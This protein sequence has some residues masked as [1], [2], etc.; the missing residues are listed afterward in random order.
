M[1]AGENGWS[2]TFRYQADGVPVLFPQGS[3]A[4]TVTITGQAITAFAYLC[5][6]YNQVDMDADSAPDA[7]GQQ[8]PLLPPSMA[9][10][11]ASLRPG[12]ELSIGY[13]DNG[14]DPLFA[15]WLDY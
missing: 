13:V 2:V 5:R 11:I 3:Q 8:S 6:S 1:E 15:R 9:V 12:A 4:L 10:A 14:S 7:A